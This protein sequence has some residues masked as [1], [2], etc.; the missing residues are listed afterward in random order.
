MD[1]VTKDDIYYLQNNKL[2]RS[3]MVSYINERQK[4]KNSILFFPIMIQYR[5]IESYKTWVSSGKT[6]FF[7]VCKDVPFDNKYLY[8]MA[9]LMRNNKF[10]FNGFMDRL[11]VFISIGYLLDM[12]QLDNIGK[13]II[14]ETLFENNYLYNIEHYLEMYLC[15]SKCLPKELLYQHL[16]LSRIVENEEIY[17][18]L[19]KIVDKETI[20][21][22]D[23]YP[24]Y[25]ELKK[26]SLDE[27]DNTNWINYWNS[28]NINFHT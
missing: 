16:Y 13:T 14:N 23:I 18:Y 21:D 20:I 22:L 17:E 1:I 2:T 25:I 27:I 8:D 9:L 28:R 15:I 7:K 11:E 5:L 19:Y 4:Y 26:E 3:E 6:I 12:Q 10:I 24:I